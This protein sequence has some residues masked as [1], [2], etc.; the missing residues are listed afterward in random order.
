MNVRFRF[1]LS[2]LCVVFLGLLAP[3]VLRASPIVTNGNFSSGWTGWF[4]TQTD[5]IVWGMPG[6]RATTGCVGQ[7]C[8]TGGVGLESDLDQYLTTVV[9]DSYTLSFDFATP[10]PPME[11]QAWFGSTDA[12]DLL[13]I[14]NTQLNSYSVSGLVATSTSTE[15]TFL[16]RQD[17]GFNTLE[18]VV[19]TDDGPA[20]PSS[21]VPEPSSLYLLGTGVAGLAGL[22]RR[23]LRA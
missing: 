5:G 11:L 23:K 13:N 21:A 8:I 20:G 1:A 3:S 10:G 2:M 12:K 19:V 6:D 16:G 18:N 15:L 14:E 7:D 4:T 22:L 17:P 9:G